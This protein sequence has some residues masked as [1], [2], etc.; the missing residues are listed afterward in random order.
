MTARDTRPDLR[1]ME[2]IHNRNEG[3]DPMRPNPLFPRRE[4]EAYY[5]AKQSNPRILD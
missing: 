3:K 1:P 2:D 4:N 5:A